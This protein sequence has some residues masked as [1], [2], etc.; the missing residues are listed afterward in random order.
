ML[1]ITGKG[2]IIKK[3]ERGKTVTGRMAV[4]KKD[5]NGEWQDQFFNVKFVGKCAEFAQIM[6]SP[7]LIEIKSAVLESREYQTDSGEKKIW[8]EII[9]F[10]FI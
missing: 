10:E 3:E 9:I 5:Q 7:K 2:K 4:G 8:T 1:N 6:D